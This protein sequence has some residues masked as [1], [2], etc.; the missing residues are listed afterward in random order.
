MLRFEN[1][2][3]QERISSLFDSWYVCGKWVQKPTGNGP[4]GG[5]DLDDF[6]GVRCRDD[7]ALQ[8]QPSR[9]FFCSAIS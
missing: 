4:Q 6:S 9:I 3:I 1:G 5:A 8:V 7:E 2:V